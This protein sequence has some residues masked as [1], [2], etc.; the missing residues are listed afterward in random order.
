MLCVGVR[1]VRYRM[2]M[3]SFQWTLGSR[4]CQQG[5]AL[6]CH[7]NFTRLL[8]STDKRNLTKAT[9][10]V[11]CCSVKKLLAEK[12]FCNLH[13]RLQAACFSTSNLLAVSK[14]D[15]EDAYLKGNISE[16][17]HW[18][19]VFIACV[20]YIVNLLNNGFG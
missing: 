13:F 11:C 9:L 7:R 2:P 20:G 6:T 5:S 4:V 12:T 3:K 8:T 18:K 19:Y 17:I 14:N 16:G 10:R 15:S 1:T